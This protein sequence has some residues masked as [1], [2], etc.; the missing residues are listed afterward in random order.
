MKNHLSV[1]KHASKCF[2]VV[3]HFSLHPSLDY[4]LNFP[5]EAVSIEFLLEA[6]KKILSLSQI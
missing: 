5:D 2:Q 3:S 1:I 6:S 4:E